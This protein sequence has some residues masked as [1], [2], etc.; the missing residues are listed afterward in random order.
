LLAGIH[1]APHDWWR[2]FYLGVENPVCRS[3]HFQYTLHYHSSFIRNLPLACIRWPQGRSPCS[4]C[5]SIFEWG[6]VKPS[7]AR[8]VQEIVDTIDYERNVGETLSWSRMVKTRL[9]EEGD[10]AVSAAVIS[11]ISGM[12]SSI[13]YPTLD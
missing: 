13:S 9:Q 10:L 2:K 8:P 11:T 4:H 6:Y 7:G 12:N 3:R 1:I 5:A